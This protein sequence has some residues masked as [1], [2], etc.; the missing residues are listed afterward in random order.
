MII[1]RFTNK[2]RIVGKATT[3]IVDRGIKNGCRRSVPTESVQP[4]RPGQAPERHHQW[5]CMAQGDVR[6]IR[7][8]AVIGPS[9]LLI[10]GPPIG[11]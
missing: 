11:P 9:S 3:L 6:S 10:G 8:G 4:H 2:K 7:G 1:P 5:D